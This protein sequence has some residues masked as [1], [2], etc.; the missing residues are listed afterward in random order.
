MPSHLQLEPFSVPQP[1]AYQTMIIGRLLAGIGI[2]I[3]SELE[4]QTNADRLGHVEIA[5]KHISCQG[6]RPDPT[7]LQK[8]F[9]PGILFQRLRRTLETLQ[10]LKWIPLQNGV[11][12]AKGQWSDME[13]GE[14]RC[15]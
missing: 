12:S 6:Q 2:G 10:S 1:R 4:D 5:R 13:A 7:E 15:G 11:L 9:S 3:S 8:I 14:R